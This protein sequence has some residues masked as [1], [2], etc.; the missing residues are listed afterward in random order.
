MTTAAER[1]FLIPSDG[2]ADADKLL[3]AR[4]DPNEVLDYTLD[5]TQR[6]NGTEAI[7]ASDW[8]VP[9]DLTV[10]GGLQPFTATTST[11]WISGGRPERVYKLTCKVTTDEERV[12]EQTLTL[13]MVE[14]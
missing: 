11:V 6:L 12:L 8:T 14:R 7:T 3:D 4:K 5:W 2:D 9:V 10:Y 13:T 1:S